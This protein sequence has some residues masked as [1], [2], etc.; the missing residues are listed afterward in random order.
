LKLRLRDL[1][2]ARRDPSAFRG[3]SARPAAMRMSRLRALQLAVYAFHR[4]GDDTDGAARHLAELY[5][6]NF[7]RPEHLPVLEEQL[8]MYVAAY[9]Q[10]GL[11]PF[12]VRDRIVI[13][14]SDSVLLTGEVPRVDMAPG[15]GYAVWLLSRG[16]FPWRTELRIPLLQAT[17]AEKMGVGESR[18]GVGFYFFETGHYEDARY[19]REDLLAARSEAAALARSLVAE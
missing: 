19:S 11:I 2:A 5:E 13:P 1:E 9:R 18:V 6:R 4:Q 17:Y 16:P 10:S 15:G 14:I 12:V 8:A 3:G 7:R